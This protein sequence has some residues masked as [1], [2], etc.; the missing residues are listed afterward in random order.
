[1]VLPANRE[2]IFYAGD[3]GPSSTTV[4][5]RL[6]FSSEEWILENVMAGLRFLID[7][8]NWNAN[9]PAQLDAAINNLT[10][11]VELFEPMDTVGTV[12]WF[13]GDPSNIPQNSLLCDGTSYAR[14]DFPLLFEAIGT[15]WGSLSASEFSVPDLRGRSPLGSGT[16]TGLSTRFVGELVGAEKHQLSIPEMPAHNHSD[17]GHSHGYVSPDNSTVAVGLGALQTVAVPGTSST[18]V[19]NANIDDTGNDIPHDNMQPSGVLVP[20]IWAI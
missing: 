8:G 14:V 5:Y 16:G 11:A 17:I 7:P 20:I 19:G 15:I 9:S 1:M 3:T 13:A 2:T 4:Q 18:D 6:I 12:A 10:A